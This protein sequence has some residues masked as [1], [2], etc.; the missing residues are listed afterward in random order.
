MPEGAVPARACRPPLP[1]TPRSSAAA[2]LRRLYE[3][4]MS[5]ASHPHAFWWLI[6]FAFTAASWFPI[7]ADLILLTPMILA[8]RRRAWFL[9]SWTAVASI[10]GGFVGYAIGF[11]FY[12]TVGRP[13]LEFYGLGEDFAR[14]RALY[15]KWGWLVVAVIAWT[16]IPWKVAT[17]ASGFLS[18]DFA[19]FALTSTAA[20]WTRYMAIGAVLYFFGP[21][22]LRF[23][24]RRLTLAFFLFVVVFLS[25]FAAVKWVF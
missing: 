22:L 4:V 2:L 18:M 10:L 12:D 16:P 19:L 15:D 8:Q 13:L 24:E 1:R 23:V 20:R 7:P 11:F 14:V 17:I 3:W 5:K 25:G 6:G 21:P 9:A